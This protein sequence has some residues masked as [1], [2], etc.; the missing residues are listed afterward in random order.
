MLLGGFGFLSRLHGLSIDNL[1]EVE[2]VLS[3]GRIVIV[4]ENEYPG[5]PHLTSYFSSLTISVT[6]SLVGSTRCRP[7]VRR[8]NSIQSTSFPRPC[9]IRGKPHLVSPRTSLLPRKSNTLLSTVGSTEQPLRPSSNTSGTAL[10]ALPA[11]STL[12]F[13]SPRAQPAKTPSLLSRCATSGQKR[14]VKSTWLPSRP[15]MGKGACLMKSTRR[16]SCIS[17]IVLRRSCAEKVG[18]VSYLLMSCLNAE[19][20]IHLWCSW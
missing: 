17:R 7:S 19:V 14:K 18:L 15:G 13:S 12:T 20:F 1:V 5:P 9:R 4:N 3:D 8:R 2:M 10:K 6:R 16:A 11:N